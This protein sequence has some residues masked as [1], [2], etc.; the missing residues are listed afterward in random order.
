MDIARTIKTTVSTGKVF[1][2]V[3]QAKKA[4]K[5]KKAKLIIVAS[6]SN[7]EEFKG[8]QFSEIPIYHYPGTN[9][10]LGVICGKPFAISVLTVIET[11]SSN[12]LAIGK[13]Q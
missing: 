6:N 2:G 13:E 10:D 12:I 11:G 3:E 8:E 9:V 5:E 1:F 4:V 7:V